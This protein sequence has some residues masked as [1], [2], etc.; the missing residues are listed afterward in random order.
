MTTS[1]IWTK[2]ANQCGFTLLEL[3]LVLLLLSLGTTLVVANNLSG[4]YQAAQEGAR[5]VEILNA[6]ANKAALDGRAYGLWVSNHRWQL[7]EWRARD[8]HDFSLPGRGGTQTLPAEWRLLLSTPD[9]QANGNA[10]QVLLLP[11]G[12]ITPFR[13]RYLYRE[14]LQAEIAVN[15]EGRVALSEASNDAL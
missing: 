1:T 13:L 15:E 12:E 7:M 8:W 9:A 5:L 6:L 11:G 4:R 14:S 10:P 2:T 3:M